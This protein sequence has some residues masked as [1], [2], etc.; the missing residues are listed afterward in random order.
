MKIIER[1]KR[2]P[3]VILD[4][5]QKKI[6]ITGRS[7]PE[8]AGIFFKPLFK[9]IQAFLEKEDTHFVICDFK[10]EYFNSSSAKYLL[11]LVVMLT[12]YRESSSNN[13]II[14][15]CSLEEDDDMQ[16]AGE[17]FEQLVDFKFNYIK[18]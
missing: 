15:W 4:Y 10:L 7:I 3:E 6:I 11:D 8:D 12:K 5:D 17:Y 13:L 14:N 2:T 16:E 9:I 18:S 1:T